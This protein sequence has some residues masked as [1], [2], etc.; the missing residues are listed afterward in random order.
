ME[1]L[2]VGVG[3]DVGMT[4][5][6]SFIGS[7]SMLEASGDF[8]PF[9][10]I[11]PD[12]FCADPGVAD[13]PFVGFSELIRAVFESMKFAFSLIS[14]AGGAM[15]AGA[16]GVGDDVDGEDADGPGNAAASNCRGVAGVSWTLGAFDDGS[17]IRREEG[18]L[19]V[20]AIS[21][22]PIDERGLAGRMRCDKGAG[23]LVDLGFGLVRVCRSSLG[24]VQI[25]TT[26]SITL[27]MEDRERTWAR[28]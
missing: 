2:A 27:S 10:E 8:T 20:A 6:F 11:R 3:V 22:L 9:S 7:P 1:G 21:R 25:W 17:E 4:D 24:Q 5:C 16:A 18:L 26:R 28:E 14:E 15:G 12:K 23:K 19:F 13:A